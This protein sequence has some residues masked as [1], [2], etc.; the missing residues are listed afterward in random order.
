V[1]FDVVPFE[2]SARGVVSVEIE[3]L[4]GTNSSVLLENSLHA[5]LSED[6][7]YVL[8]PY[9]ADRT[10]VKWKLQ[11]GPNPFR[12]VDSNNEHDYPDAVSHPK[13]RVGGDIE[14]V[15]YGDKSDLGKSITSYIA[16]GFLGWFLSPEDPNNYIASVQYRCSYQT[17]QMPKSKLYRLAKIADVRYTPRLEHIQLAMVDLS[18]VILFDLASESSESSGLEWKPQKF[19]FNTKS[20]A[21]RSLEQ[22]TGIRYRG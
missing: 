2:P 14:I 4:T 7:I 18:N 21:I 3:D 20:E 12:A 17:G 15:H 1:T 13:A 9:Q 22:W 8:V 11:L 19:I 16:F 10:I 5:A 6:F